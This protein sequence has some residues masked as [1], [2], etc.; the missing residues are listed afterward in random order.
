MNFVKAKIQ[1]NQQPW[2]RHYDNAKNSRLGKTAYGPSAQTT[3]TCGSGSY[4]SANPNNQNVINCNIAKDDGLAAWMQALL[5]IHSGD[6][7]YANNAIVIINAW[8]VSF[9]LYCIVCFIEIN[10]ENRVNKLTKINFNEANDNTKSN[11]PLQAA[12]M[13]SMY[14]KAAELLRHGKVNGVSS[15]WTTSAAGIIN[16]YLLL[17]KTKKT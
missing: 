16:I 1:A 8:Y 13:S 9:R 7:K 2:L 15:G 17:N 10:C 11:G 3:L 12:W 6:Q 4:S 5:W 14:I